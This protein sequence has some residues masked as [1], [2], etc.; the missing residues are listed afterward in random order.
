M[1]N[2][3]DGKTALITGASSGIGLEVA[4]SLAKMNV[5][6][7]LLSKT[8]Q[9]LQLVKSQILSTSNVKISLIDIDVSVH[10]DVKNALQNLLLN[11]QIDILVNSAGFALGLNSIDNGDI[12]DWE[13]MI[14]TN[15]KGLLYVSRYILPHMKTLQSAHV[16][17]LGSVAGKMAYPNGNVYCATKAAVHSL[18][19]SFN[20]DLFGTGVKVTTIAP[21]AVNTN[22]S[23][24]RFKNDTQ[25]AN[26]V[27]EGYTPLSAKDIANT[28]LHVLNTPPH[29]NIQ[30]V[31]IMPTAQRNPYM[32]SK[33]L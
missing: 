22:F 27:Y 9:K 14:D 3:L 26:K 16:I 11:T 24:V 6:L 18:N 23:N 8:L 4:I 32:L 15:L 2:Y 29:V 13:K 30:Y 12:E 21:G 17:N 19:E 28:I 7:V 31:D 5:N 20:V 10:E 1:Q 25:K 33:N